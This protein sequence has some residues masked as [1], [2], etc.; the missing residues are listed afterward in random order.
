ME[1]SNIVM[2]KNIKL[3]NYV[4]CSK[5]AKICSAV[6]IASMAMKLETIHQCH[7][8]LRHH[9]ATWREIRRKLLTTPAL[10]KVTR[11]TSQKHP[12]HK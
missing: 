2:N 3:S 10:P 9:R 1:C 12:V 5:N 6:Q 8:C 11:P 7:S 4:T